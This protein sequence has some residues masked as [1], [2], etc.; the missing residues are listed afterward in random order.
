[1]LDY[2]RRIG[3]F[4]ADNVRC[5][6]VHRIRDKIGS[7]TRTMDLHLFVASRVAHVFVVE[8]RK[9]RV[10]PQP[11]LTRLPKRDFARARVPA[12]VE[13]HAGGAF[14]IGLVCFLLFSLSHTGSLRCCPISD[15]GPRTCVWEA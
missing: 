14:R 11:S 5:Q 13:S 12:S 3:D 1:V 4:Q 2:L 15:Q 9:R 7:N 6:G 8:R 10:W